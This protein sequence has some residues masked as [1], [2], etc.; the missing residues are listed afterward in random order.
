MK[1]RLDATPEE[2]EEKSE[3]LIK[4]L[5][6]V[7]RSAV[8]DLSESLEKALPPKE[9]ELKYPVLR[10]LLQQT[11]DIYEQHMQD[12]LK[13]IGKVLDGSVKKSYDHTKDV[14]I[15]D[16]KAYDR[17]KRILEEMG[18]VETDFL[19][20]GSLYGKSTNELI[21]LAQEQR[22]ENLS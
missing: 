2:L 3:K 14:A 1:F 19:E 20:G 15:K 10:D 12:M 17:V 8:P 4:T 16:G 7:F 13:A 9:Q 5:S 22:K 21:A 18:Y 6:D 11:T